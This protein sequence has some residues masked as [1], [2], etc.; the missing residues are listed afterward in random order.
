MTLTAPA[1]ANSS[2]LFCLAEICYLLVN[3]YSY[4]SF[5]AMVKH[6]YIVLGSV[7]N[8]LDF[9]CYDTY[10]NRNYKKIHQNGKL[11]YVLGKAWQ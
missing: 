2:C 9:F 5:Y 6:M 8:S 10:T 3:S 11:L 4:I 7:N 1:D